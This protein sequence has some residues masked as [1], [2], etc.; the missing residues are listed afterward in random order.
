MSESQERFWSPGSD[1]ICFANS[2]PSM[3]GITTSVTIKSNSVSACIRES[4]SSADWAGKALCLISLSS[5][6]I[7]DNTSSLS[8]TTRIRAIQNL[9]SLWIV[10]NKGRIKT[11]VIHTADSMRFKESQELEGRRIVGCTAM[12]SCSR[13]AKIFGSFRTISFN[14]FR[15]SCRSIG[16][17]FSFCIAATSSWVR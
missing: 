14:S 15:N 10:F 8:S 16:F 1:K 3:P 4:A 2:R 13:S 5:S 7:V 6:E 9:I 17:N 11:Y 12:I